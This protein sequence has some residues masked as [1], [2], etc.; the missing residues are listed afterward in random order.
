MTE[1]LT[2]LGKRTVS[3][4]NERGRK[5]QR[6]VNAYVFSSSNPPTPSPAMQTIIIESLA[7]NNGKKQNYL[8]HFCIRAK[9]FIV[10]LYFLCMKVFIFLF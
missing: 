5:R 9:A 6:E 7:T 8:I 2:V 4:P 3:F 1:P 10:K